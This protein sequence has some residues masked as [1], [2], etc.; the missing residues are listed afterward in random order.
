MV[1]DY[2]RSLY[3]A[4]CNWVEGGEPGGKIRWLRAAPGAKIFPGEFAFGSSIW[5]SERGDD[6][7]PV[8]ETRADHV[9]R[10]TI[11]SPNPGQHIDGDPAWMLSGV[12]A[13]HRNDPPSPCAGQ[14]A[15]LALSATCDELVGLLA[16]VELSL[17][18]TATVSTTIDIRA[19][20]AFEADYV[21]PPANHVFADLVLDA[22]AEA[23]AAIAARAD[24]ALDATAPPPATFAAVAELALDATADVLVAIPAIADLALDCTM[25]VSLVFSGAKV[26]NFP[27]FFALGSTTGNIGFTNVDYD[28]GPYWN[29]GSDSISLTVPFSGIYAVGFQSNVFGFPAGTLAFS[30]E[31]ELFLNGS[32]TD[33]RL[34]QIFPNSPTAGEVFNAPA[35]ELLLTAG[36]QL[37]LVY[38]CVTIGAG[39]ISHSYNFWIQFQGAP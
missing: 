6:D 13:A 23:L 11:T 8:G 3:E 39:A 25:E 30:H 19:D 28:N 35:T 22:T 10:R 17:N 14:F 34:M 33:L 32:A 5:E 38:T 29:L 26:D 2:L 12:P 7:P 36:D 4:P 16:L 31:T 24:L 37:R 9:W 1:L 15:D 18:A 27:V 21:M 20:L